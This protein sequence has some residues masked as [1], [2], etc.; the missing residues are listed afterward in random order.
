MRATARAP[1]NKTLGI[2]V[3][4]VIDTRTADSIRGAKWFSLFIH[5]KPDQKEM[6]NGK[7]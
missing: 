2:I 7:A 6:S 1:L 4:L 3:L 5:P